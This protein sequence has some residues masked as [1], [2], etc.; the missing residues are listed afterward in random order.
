MKGKLKKLLRDHKGMVDA[1]T[2]VLIAVVMVT[3]V[4]SVVIFYNVGESVD[5]TTTTDSMT[6]TQTQKSENKTVSDATSDESLTMAEYPVNDS[7]LTVKLWNNSAKSWN[8]INVVTNN[9]T[10]S[11]KTV[12]VKNNSYTYNA[13]SNYTKTNVTYYYVGDQTHTISKNFDDTSVTATKYSSS[14]NWSSISST[15][16]S[17]SG[18]TVTIGKAA[19]A[20]NFNQTKGNVSYMTDKATQVS[21]TMSQASDTFNMM[22]VI[23]IVAVA[24]II[25]SVLLGYFVMNRP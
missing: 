11:G 19:F 22:N 9:V 2:V 18:Y 10:I 3:I 1:G 16:I 8:T 4:I 23:P 24:S 5:Y 7:R 15:H 25:I 17:V 13:D 20:D 6:Y 14:R 12:T 21:D